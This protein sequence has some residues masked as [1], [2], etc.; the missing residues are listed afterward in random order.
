[1]N[2]KDFGNF[3]RL[4]PDQ[5]KRKCREAKANEGS[6]EL[7]GRGWYRVTKTGTGATSPLDITPDDTRVMTLLAEEVETDDPFADLLRLP[8]EE[9]DRR[10]TIADIQRIRGQTAESRREYEEQLQSELQPAILALFLPVRRFL[11]DLELTADQIADL[12]GKLS[13][14]L[15]ELRTITQKHTK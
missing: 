15:T 5:I 10:K 11:D 12:N 2:T 3:F 4:S 8:Q 14:A 9:L 7:P 1:M 13:E 6:F